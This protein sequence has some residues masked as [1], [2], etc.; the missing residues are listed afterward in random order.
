MENRWCCNAPLEAL[1][2]MLVQQVSGGAA[3]AS[4]FIV[5]Y[6]AVQYSTLL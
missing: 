1:E 3:P 2:W 5:L 6:S 4:A